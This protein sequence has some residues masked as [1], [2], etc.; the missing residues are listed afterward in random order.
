MW[1]E[2]SCFKD[3][4]NIPNCLSNLPWQWCIQLSIHFCGLYLTGP[5]NILSYHE[6]DFWVTP[7]L[8]NECLQACGCVVF[9]ARGMQA[10]I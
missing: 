9:G 10:P 1:N 3:S 4:N 7:L 5:G 6:A 2:K 8:E